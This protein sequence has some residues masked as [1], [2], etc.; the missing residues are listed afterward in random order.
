MKVAILISIAGDFD[1]IPDAKHDNAPVDIGAPKM[2]ERTRTS[3][4]RLSAAVRYY[5]I[6]WLKE[7]S[8]L[9]GVKVVCGKNQ[10]VSGSYAS[11][12]YQR[13]RN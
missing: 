8:R 4:S 11:T 13:Q 1:I 12:S 10:Q 7:F 3:R 9:S 5:V 6:R 2:P